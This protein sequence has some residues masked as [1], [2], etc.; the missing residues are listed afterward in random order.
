MFF[1]RKNSVELSEKKPSKIN[2]ILVVVFILSLAWLT[3]GQFHPSSGILKIKDHTIM[4]YIANTPAM[5]HKGL[6]KRA[7]LDTHDGM[8]L[9]FPETARHAIVMRDMQFPIDIMWIHNGKVVDMVKHAQIEPGVPESKLRRYR[10][11]IEANTVLEVPA[12]WIDGH[13]VVIGDTVA[14][15]R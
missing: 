14:T 5:L 1:R 13:N 7:D 11:R 2:K 6:G 9:L 4:V 12:G 3:I 10:P 8:V 15:V